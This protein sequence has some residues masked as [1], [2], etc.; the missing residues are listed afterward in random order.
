MVHLWTLAHRSFGRDEHLR[1]ARS[2]AW[3]AWEAP[4][5]FPDLC[6]GLAGRAYALLSVYRHTGDAEW[7]DRARALGGR[8]HSAL[9]RG[10]RFAH[11]MSLFKGEPGIVLLG[12]DLAAPEA[13]CMPFFESEGWP[14]DG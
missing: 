2:S 6:C 4:S 13:A 10:S 9:L 3:S 5:G 12:A 11:P 1:L 14:T 7:L 8:A